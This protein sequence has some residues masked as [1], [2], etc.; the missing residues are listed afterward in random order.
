VGDVLDHSALQRWRQEQTSFITEICRDPETGKPFDLLPAQKR[1]FKRAFKFNPDGRLRYPEQIYACPKKSGKT[2]TA[3]L[4]L[5]TT[6]LVYG[7]RFAEAYAIANDLEQSVG[8]VFEACRR[9]VECSPYL[10]REAEV[11]ARRITFPATGASITAIASDYAGAAGSN[12]SISSFDELWGYTS[13]NARRMW[14]EMVPVPTRR[15]SCRLVTSYAGFEGESELLQELHKRGTSLPLVAK[16]LYAGDGLLCFWSHSPIAPWQDEQ[17]LTQMRSS[18][19]PNQYARMIENRFTSTDDTFVDLDW[20]DACVDHD[21]RPVVADKSISVWVGVDASV[22]RDSTAIV[23]VTWDDKAKKVRLVWHR[24]FTPRKS[25]P[26]D[27][28]QM[29]EETILDLRKRF[30]VRR[31]EFDPY[32]MQSSAQRLRRLSVP[33][34]EYPQS[35]PNI[36]R[37]SQCLYELIKSQGI[38]LYPDD[39]IRLAVQRSVAVESTRGW[40]ISKEKSS[41]KID[42]VVSLAMAAFAAVRWGQRE[43]LQMVG[44]PFTINTETGAIV[45]PDPTAVSTV[46]WVSTSGSRSPLTEQ[47]HH[48]GRVD[49]SNRLSD[50]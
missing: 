1:F 47:I 36:T 9:I 28:E 35:V 46:G 48:G 21:L 37:A 38:T 40:K 43:Q 44:V 17:W 7:G 13:E 26:I 45:K 50:W 42:V 22:K 31:V 18:L 12:P 15:V 20:F 41:H 14:D 30:L 2:A 11:T 25:D 19:R 33:M 5:L 49:Y 10:K 29:I 24:I 27:F 6:C 32:Q 4:H 8:R 16:D 39:A 34:F 3:A 23:A